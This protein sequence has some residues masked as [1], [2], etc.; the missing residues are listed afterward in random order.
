[1]KILKE[2]ERQQFIENM[3]KARE[4]YARKLMEN[5]GFQ[6]FRLLI[7]QKRTNYKKAILHRRRTY[8][9]RYFLMWYQHTKEVW[10]D[11][12][13]MAVELH[14]SVI[15]KRYFIV[16][17]QVYQIR[18]SR[19]LVAIDW[20]EMKITEKLL[21]FWYMKSKTNRMLEAGKMKNAEAHYNW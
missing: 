1:M 15:V 14:E 13:R 8:M 11:K 20:Y 18:Q 5:L 12:R 16:W 7:R 3:K 19:M 17:R 21:R 10:T 9:R 2:Q 4:H 6:A